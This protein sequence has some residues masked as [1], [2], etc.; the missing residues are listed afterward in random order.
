MVVCWLV[1]EKVTPPISLYEPRMHQAGFGIDR[2][3]RSI[4]LDIC[5]EYRRPIQVRF[6]TRRPIGIQ[7]LGDRGRHRGKRHIGCRSFGEAGGW[8]RG[9]LCL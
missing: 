4:R 9:G 3:G 1:S 5:S 7:T 2:P 8:S 6:G